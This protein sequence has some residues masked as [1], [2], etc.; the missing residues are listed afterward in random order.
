MVFKNAQPI[1]NCHLD[2]DT[3][4]TSV[5]VGVRV[6]ITENRDKQQNVVNGPMATIYMFHNGT[7]LL[8]L[9]GNKIVT[10]HPLT[11]QSSNGKRTFYLFRVAYATPCVKLKVK[12]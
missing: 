8:K 11:F 4:M 9:P 1:A 3:V 2:S 7:V 10:T 5:Y 6:M 12:T